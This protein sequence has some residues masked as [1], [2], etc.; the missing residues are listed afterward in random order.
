M[1][2][3]L[4]LEQCLTKELEKKN[5]QLSTTQGHIQK[6]T[7]RKEVATD[8]A[9]KDRIQALI[10]LHTEH[11]AETQTIDVEVKAQERFDKQEEKNNKLEK[12]Q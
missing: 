10:V 12:V 9:E 5:T 1:K 4:T 8:Q 7:A 3:S 11:L 6:L 2:E